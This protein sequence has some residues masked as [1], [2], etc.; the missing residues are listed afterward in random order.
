[1]SPGHRWNGSYCLACSRTGTLVLWLK[2]SDNQ[3]HGSGSV[4]PPFCRPPRTP[5]FR[6]GDP[7]P[8]GRP[9]IRWEHHR[10]GP[11][12]A[13]CPSAQAESPRLNSWAPDYM[14]SRLSPA[15]LP[16]AVERIHDKQRFYP[17]SDFWCSSKPFIPPKLIAP[18][19]PSHQRSWV[20]HIFR[21]DD[22]SLL[23]ALFFSNFA[24]L[25]E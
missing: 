18:C 7:G 16:T 15:F 21:R 14:S 5:D 12:G 1:M 9:P 3:F 17:Q 11:Q 23:N 20:V 4:S 10:L 22:Q 8:E 24:E 19:K 25:L 2:G 6:R 13:L